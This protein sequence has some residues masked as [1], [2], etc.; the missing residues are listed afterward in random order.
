MKRSLKLYQN[1]EISLSAHAQNSQAD[2]LRLDQKAARCP[3][4]KWLY[5]ACE[6]SQNVPGGKERGE[7]VVFAG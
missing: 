5:V 4:C 3:T 1:L 7:T 2:I 6:N